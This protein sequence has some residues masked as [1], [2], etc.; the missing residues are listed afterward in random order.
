MPAE[1]ERWNHNIHYHRRLLAALPRRGRRALDVGCGDGML[2][3]ELATRFDR[4]VGID[5]DQPSIDLARETTRA[6]DDSL[7][8]LVGD[9]LTH[10]FESASLDAITCVAALH[11]MDTVA[12]LERMQEL[13]APGGRVAIVGLAR[14]RY[15]IDLPRDAA[16]SVATRV[17]R[18]TGNR[19]FWQHSAPTVWP[20]PETFAQTRRI[21]ERVLP[22]AR[23][24]RLLLWRYLLTWTKPVV[25]SAL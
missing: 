10:P 19:S 23:F 21:A 18:R 1:H 3:R 8:Y 13:L 12:G 20:P 9:F 16:A 25:Q 14:N 22:G 7:E 17:L 5:L 24:R 15:P 6:G 4:V 2:V 11:H